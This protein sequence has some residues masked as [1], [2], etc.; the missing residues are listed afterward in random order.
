MADPSAS[1]DGNKKMEGVEE[2]DDITFND[3][4]SKDTSD[5][6]KV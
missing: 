4:E 5:A 3:R 2:D 1:D 6:E